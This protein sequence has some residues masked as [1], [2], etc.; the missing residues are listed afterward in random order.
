MEGKRLPADEEL[1]LFLQ[2]R[3]EHLDQLILPTLEKGDWVILDRYYFSTLAYQSLNGFT[4]EALRQ[5]NEAFAPQPD[6]LIILQLTPQ[7][8]LERIAARNEG[9]TAFEKVDLL[10]HC[11]N[12]FNSLESEPFAHLINADQSIESITQNIQQEI[13]TRFQLNA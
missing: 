1:D 12:V 2:D 4:I 6:L 13:Q 11:A 5:K 10:T 3:Q 7:I 9:T 8:S